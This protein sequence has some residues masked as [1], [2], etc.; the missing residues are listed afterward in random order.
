LVIKPTMARI[1]V[2]LL[3]E[4]E[5][6]SY[7]P[8]PARLSQKSPKRN[9]CHPELVEGYIIY[10]VFMLRQAQHDRLLRQP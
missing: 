7:L 1:E 6:L 3:G 5:L 9:R 2:P 8:P 4:V 10:N